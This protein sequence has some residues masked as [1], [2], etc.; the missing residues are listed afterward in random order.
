V[1]SLTAPQI[2]LPAALGRPPRRANKNVRKGLSGKLSQS[3]FGVAAP[4]FP[5]P[6]TVNVHHKQYKTFA[7]LKK[8]Q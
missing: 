7:F 5:A 2:L 3:R 1:P 4:W 8:I 6:Y